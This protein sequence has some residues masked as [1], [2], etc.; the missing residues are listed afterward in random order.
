MNHCVKIHKFTAKM[1]QWFNCNRSCIDLQLSAGRQWTASSLSSSAASAARAAASQVQFSTT[2]SLRKLVFH[3]VFFCGFQASGF[4]Y[5][6]LS[7]VEMLWKRHLHLQRSLD[8]HSVV[9]GHGSSFL[10]KARR[11][12]GVQFTHQFPPWESFLPFEFRSFTTSPFQ[13]PNLRSWSFCPILGQHASR[14]RC[15]RQRS[16]RNP[17]CQQLWSDILHTWQ[18]L[19][20]MRWQVRSVNVIKHGHRWHGSWGM[21]LFR[22]KSLVNLLGFISPSRCSACR[23]AEASYW[24]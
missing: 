24:Q 6:Y 12:F 17:R 7:N 23:L 14:C 20:S 10:S 19:G 8:D 11:S 1:Y 3:S 16:L 5:L 21:V 13:D 9:V 2:I 15:W 22:P 4:Q 18:Q